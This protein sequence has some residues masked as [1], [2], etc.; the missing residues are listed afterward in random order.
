MIE[1]GIIDTLGATGLKEEDF[2]VERERAVI[3]RA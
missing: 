1:E 3:R 2:R